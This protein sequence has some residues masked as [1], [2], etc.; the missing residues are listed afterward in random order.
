MLSTVSKTETDAKIEILRLGNS[1][2]LILK[3]GVVI[4]F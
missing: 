3:K 4:G 1:L 2:T